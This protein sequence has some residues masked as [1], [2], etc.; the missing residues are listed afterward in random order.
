M[1]VDSSFQVFNLRLEGQSGGCL[2]LVKGF[3]L[4]TVE[5][6]PDLQF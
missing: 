4:L 2:A 3:D 5:S 6:F 1:W